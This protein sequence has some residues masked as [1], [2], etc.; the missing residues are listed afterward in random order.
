MPLLVHFDCCDSLL[1][2][3]PTL[4]AGTLGSGLLT[5]SVCHMQARSCVLKHLLH[6]AHV[7][8]PKIGR[9]AKI[10]TLTW[11]GY[12]NNLAAQ[13]HDMPGS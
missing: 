6:T 9:D 3:R 7:E 4:R 10:F 5:Q 12:E 8:Q 1:Q 13:D 2:L 11:E